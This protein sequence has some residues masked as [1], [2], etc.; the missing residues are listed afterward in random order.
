MANPVDPDNVAIRYLLDYAQPA[1]A[2]LLDIGCGRGRRTG[3]LADAARSVIAI[4]PDWDRFAEAIENTPQDV[5]HR[6]RFV[7]AR[8]EALPFPDETFDVAVFAWSF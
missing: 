6:V 3:S 2:R 5:R 1:G 4:D 8:A 7:Q